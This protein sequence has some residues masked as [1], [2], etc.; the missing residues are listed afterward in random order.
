M[1]DIYGDLW[2]YEKQKGSDSIE[3]ADGAASGGFDSVA[4]YCNV[5]TST[6]TGNIQSTMGQNSATFFP[7]ITWKNKVPYGKEYSGYL[8]N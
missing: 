1:V 6:V 4:I 7:D 3:K 5:T 2:Y 8:S